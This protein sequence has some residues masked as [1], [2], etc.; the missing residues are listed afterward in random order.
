LDKNSWATLNFFRK[1]SDGEV[2]FSK[3]RYIPGFYG[4]R[5]QL[6]LKALKGVLPLSVVKMGIR[7][8]VSLL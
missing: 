6:H 5:R 2:L 3:F 4:K 8:K 1:L 7:A